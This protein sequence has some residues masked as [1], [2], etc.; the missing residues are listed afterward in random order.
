MTDATRITVP[1]DVLSDVVC[2]WCFIGKRRLEA[3]L[4]MLRS[5]RPEIDAVVSWHPF[6]LNP[7]LPREGADRR[8]HREA[9]FGGA[10]QVEAIDA[11]LAA[12]GAS[13]G[14]EFRFDA[15]VRQPNTF[16]A[17]RLVSWAQS[18]ADAGPL[19]ERLFEAFFV[20]GRDVG[21]RA[22]LAQIAA[23]AG[24]DRA[25]AAS[26]LD[27]DAFA[28]RVAATES[29]ARELGVGGVPFFIINERVAVSG[30]QEPA[31][32]REAIEQSLI[33]ANA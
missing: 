8:S 32:L 27:S 3:A 19:V 7:Q 18:Q 1:I 13:S 24:L 23:E 15:I 16:D 33:A 5:T 31:H 25:A 2:P 12:V 21:D 11:R 28:D 9:K 6:Q 20:A 30:A 29:R 10:A 17:H 22:E 26:M 4:A 14:I